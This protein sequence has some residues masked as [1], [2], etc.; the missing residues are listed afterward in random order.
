MDCENDPLRID[1]LILN[2]IPLWFI[3]KFKNQIIRR[4]ISATL[5]AYMISNRVFIQLSSI[6]IFTTDQNW[7]GR[8]L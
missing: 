4:N 8:N 6:S 1:P 5:A 3:S 7:S 2:W